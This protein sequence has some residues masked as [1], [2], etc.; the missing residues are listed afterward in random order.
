MTKLLHYEILCVFV[1]AFLR[2]IMCCPQKSFRARQD[3]HFYQN[4][5]TSGT[6]ST[7]GFER[8]RAGGVEPS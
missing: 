8:Q 2:L 7:T 5:S 3:K 6:F 4:G 1:L